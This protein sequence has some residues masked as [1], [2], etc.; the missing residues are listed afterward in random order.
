MGPRKDKNRSQTEK[1]AELKE[2]WADD[3]PL[4]KYDDK[5]YGGVQFF[6]ENFNSHVVDNSSDLND[7]MHQIFDAFCLMALN[8]LKTQKMMLTN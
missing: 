5:T 6:V 8:S 4:I 2:G 7:G 3:L 1:C